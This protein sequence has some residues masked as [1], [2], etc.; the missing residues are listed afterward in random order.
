MR[1]REDFQACHQLRCDHV[2]ATATTTFP[3]FSMCDEVSV[4]WVWAL[5]EG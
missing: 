4:F 5:K 3:L 1:A 2:I